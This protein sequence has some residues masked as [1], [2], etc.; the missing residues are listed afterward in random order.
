MSG[1]F[2]LRANL[3]RRHCVHIR[4]PIF[5]FALLC[6]LT[7]FSGC[8]PS[9]EAAS[10]S[11]FLV[12]LNNLRNARGDRRALAAGVRTFPTRSESA[13]IAQRACSDA[14]GNLLDAEDAI[15]VAEAKVAAAQANGAPLDSALTEVAL[16]EKAL[17]AAKEAM[18]AC[19]LAAAK[20]AAKVR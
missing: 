12:E 8:T 20:L 3:V 9:E 11:A 6:T 15:A 2:R 18:P 4:G 13:K 19:D 14:Y 16:A 17:L 1:L 7:S 5:R 10:D